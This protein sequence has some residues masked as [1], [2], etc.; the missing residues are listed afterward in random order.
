MINISGHSLSDAQTAVLSKGLSFSPNN[1]INPFQL[2]VDTFKLSR[3]MHLKH[4]FSAQTNVLSNGN[5]IRRNSGNVE[6]TREYTAFKK[7]SVFLPASNLNP[8]ICTYSRL[9]ENDLSKLCSKRFQYRDNLSAAER[10]ALKELQINS[11]LVIR[12]ADKGGAVVVQSFEQY[13]KGI[14]N[15]LM[16]RDFY[17]PLRSNPTERI[18][19]EIDATITLALDSGWI[20]E[21]EKEFLITKHPVCPVLYGLPKIHKSLVDPPLRPIVSGNGSLTE[22]LSQFVDFFIKKLVPS[23]PSF[24]GDT[25]DLLNV[26]NGFNVEATTILVTMDV[27]SL[28]TNIPHEGGL[29]ALSHYLNTRPEGVVPPS[30]FLITLT[31][32]ALTMN[33][34]QYTGSFYLQ[35]QGTAMGAAFAPNYAN[36]FM[37]HWEE[38]YI[39]NPSNPFLSKII[40]WRRYIDDILLIWNGTAEELERFVIYAN[41]VDSHLS[42]TE[43]H[44][45]VSVNFLDLTIYKDAGNTLQ[46]TI[47]RKPLSRNTLLKADSNH[48]SVL[49]RNIPVGQFLRL[50]RNC[51]TDVEFVNKSL[52]MKERFLQRG[53]NVADITSAIERA[54][55]TDRK[56]LLLKRRKRANSSRICFS[57]EF[58]PVAG[59]IK[60]IVLKHWPILQSDPLLKDFTSE[61]PRISF[62]RSRNIKDKLVHSVVKSPTAQPSWL[63]TPPSGFYRCGH[64]V[65]CSNSH[66]TKVFHH[67]RSGKEFKINGF[68]NCNTT[69]VIYMIKCVCSKIYIG[70]T[71]RALKVR[72]AEHKTAIRVKNMDYAIARHYAAANHGTV[73][74]LKFCGIE[75]VSLSV[76]GG[77]IVNK[78]LRREAYWIDT[79]NS[80]EPNGLN[81][82]LSFSCF[83]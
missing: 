70:Q 39:Y 58:N 77:D 25:T 54:R 46:S 23:L 27:Q 33:Y 6:V 40:L 65:H 47:F 61:P 21:K 8:S 1:S 72:I 60:N 55:L 81:E 48:P 45:V 35:T 71:K 67:P 42:F 34:F 10:I 26:I 29:Q 53:Y 30:D 37:G 59:Q 80:V 2:K 69:H 17:V 83:L 78:L 50:K 13:D 52:E 9:V 51:S 36:L 18:K 5:T 28:Y 73:S 76:R 3:Q 62:R 14:K 68:I 15:Q 4:F 63:P 64:C 57:T 7:K 66:D 44:S 32:M 12:N 38:K 24:L 41:S 31:E 22:P 75:K 82:S 16:N 19:L 56:S 20:T 11:N 43:E 49:K 74:S 79:L